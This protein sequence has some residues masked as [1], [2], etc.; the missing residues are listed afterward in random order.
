M[1]WLNCS[2]GQRHR[3]LHSVASFVAHTHT[4]THC[5]VAGVSISIQPCPIR[6][7]TQTRARRQ[8]GL[9]LKYLISNELSLMSAL[10]RLASPSQA[11]TILND[12][13]IIWP[14]Q[15]LTTETQL[16][17]KKVKPGPGDGPL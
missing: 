14:E 4:L 17:A 8:S 7:R 2:L 15:V 3:V 9:S 12:V 13:K 1:S 5:K 16:E 10:P 11:N 6:S